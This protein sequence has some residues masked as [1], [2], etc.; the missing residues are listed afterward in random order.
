MLVAVD[1]E[2]FSSTDLMISEQVE[3]IIFFH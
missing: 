1:T 3:E 2:V